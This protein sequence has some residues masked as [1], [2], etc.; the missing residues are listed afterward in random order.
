MVGNEVKIS[1]YKEGKTHSVTIKPAKL[2]VIEGQHVFMDCDAN[3]HLNS[4]LNLRVFIDSDSD[5]RLSRRIFRDT[6]DYHISL[7]DSITNYL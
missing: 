6:Q 3:K 5:V 2:L 7:N 4:L 1:Y